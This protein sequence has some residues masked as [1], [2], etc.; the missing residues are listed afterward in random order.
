MIATII[1]ATAIFGDF[2]VRMYY[3]SNSTVQIIGGIIAVVVI[4]TVLMFLFW[5][6]PE[7]RKAVLR[8]FG[9][10]EEKRKTSRRKVTERTI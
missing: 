7:A 6:I 2:S 1:F 8:M 3:S 4:A 9:L 5:S 10:D